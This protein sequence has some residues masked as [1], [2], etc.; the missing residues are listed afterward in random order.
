MTSNKTFWRFLIRK[1]YVLSHFEGLKPNLSTN[2]WKISGKYVKAQ[3]NSQYISCG[4]WI[5]VLRAARK[6]VP[7]EFK[8]VTGIKCTIMFYDRGFQSTAK[9]NSKEKTVLENIFEIMILWRHKGYFFSSKC[10]VYYIMSI[11][12]LWIHRIPLNM[13]DIEFSK[14]IVVNRVV[15]SR[16]WMK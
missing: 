1:K 14:R 8:L 13:S 6:I 5:R 16:T 12:T 3:Y 2:I 7:H 4:I 9:I 11:K 10:N 15:A